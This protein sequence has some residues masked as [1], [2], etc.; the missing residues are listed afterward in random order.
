MSNIVDYVP[1]LFLGKEVTRNANV[2][3]YVNI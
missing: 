3:K 2:A 1:S